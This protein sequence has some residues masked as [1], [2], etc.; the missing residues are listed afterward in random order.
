MQTQNNSMDCV[1]L[2]FNS[3][4]DKSELVENGFKPLFTW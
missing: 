3:G 2:P 4:L 1:A